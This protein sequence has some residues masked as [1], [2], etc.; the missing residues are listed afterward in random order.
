MVTDLTVYNDRTSQSK[1]QNN[2]ARTAISVPRREYSLYAIAM[3][4]QSLFQI[5]HGE[6]V[7]Y[8]IAK[9]EA[10]CEVIARYPPLIDEPFLKKYISYT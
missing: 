3:R 5:V 8:I 10:D 6:S 9:F 4:E 1:Y 7:F 2:T